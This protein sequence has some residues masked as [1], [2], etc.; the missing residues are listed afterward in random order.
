MFQKTTTLILNQIGLFA[1]FVNVSYQPPLKSNQLVRIFIYFRS[2]LLSSVL[3][4][5][6]T[7]SIA[8]KYSANHIFFLLFRTTVL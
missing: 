3:S 8:P 6:L 2:T 7:V 5:L 4:A 1:V